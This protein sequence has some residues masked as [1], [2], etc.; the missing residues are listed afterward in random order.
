GGP[1]DKLLSDP[2][3]ASVM[4]R[5]L[6]RDTLKTEERDRLLAAAAKLPAGPVRDL[7]EGYLPVDERGGR[8]LGSNPRPRAILALAGDAARGEAL[9]WSQAVNCGSCHKVGDRGTPVGPDLSAV[10][11]LRAREDLLE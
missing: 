7:F 6:G 3:L 4:A 9:F 8:K 1:P 5:K 10:G 2:R 11:K